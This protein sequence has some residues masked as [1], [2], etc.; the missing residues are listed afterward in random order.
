MEILKAQELH[1]PGIVEVWEE[2]A[3]FHE[4]FDP[5]FPMK[6]DVSSGYEVHLR[7]DMA[8]ET[9]RVLV[10]LDKEKVV[11]YVM[12]LIKK[13]DPAWQRERSGY[14]EEMAV[15]ANY[16]RRGIGEKLLKQIIDWFKEEKL[17]YIELSVAAKNKVGYSFWKKHGFKDYLHILYLMP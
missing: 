7:E 8:K 17:D 6:D 13:T 15:T 5:R 1:I 10:A 14:I 12:A 2:F 16:R 4:P 3:H 11:G 9:T